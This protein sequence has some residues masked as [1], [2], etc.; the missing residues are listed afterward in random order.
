M[1]LFGQIWIL[2]FGEALGRYI[3][4]YRE[5][6]FHPT[7]FGGY[8]WVLQSG[9][10]RRIYR[11]LKP[12]VKRL[13]AGDYV[14]LPPKILTTISVELPP[15]VMAEYARLEKDFILQ[16]KGGEVTAKNVG[17]L[18]SKLRQAANGAIYLDRSMD[19]KVRDAGLGRKR[20]FGKLHDEK[21][22][23]LVDLIE[24]L[25]GQ[26]TL[27]AYQFVHDLERLRPALAWLYDGDPKK[28]PY[29]GGGVSPKRGKELEDA[30][31]RSE[32]PALPVHPAS[33][34]HGVNL[35]R[36][37]RS[38]IWFGMTYDLDHY[39]QLMR[40]IWRQ[41]QKKRVFIYH[42]VAKRTVEQKILRAIG[43][44]AKTQNDLLDALKSEYLAGE[45][46]QPS[47]ATGRNSPSSVGKTG[48]RTTRPARAQRR[49]K[50]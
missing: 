21:L 18:T 22:R 4:H 40:R 43:K 33:I 25:S 19:E 2:D 44:K 38:L 46:G 6:Y 42:L 8:T 48:R 10:E 12:L 35:Q 36:G 3:T 47:S 17:V 1:D 13:D 7:G 29:I 41:G 14:K 26:P 32:L 15:K 49:G 23:A 9:G 16:L 20:R 37:G 28:V 31:N 24:E 5:Q 50:R 45:S 39:D 30:W 11:K 27:I 34:S